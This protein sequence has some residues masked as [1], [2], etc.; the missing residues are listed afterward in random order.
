VTSTGKSPTLTDDEVALLQERQMAT[1]ATVMSDGSPQATP[2]W[3]D[4]D[5]EAIIFN[6]V[7]GHVKHRNLLRDPRVAVSVYDATNPFRTLI[8]RGVCELI[9]EG[10][11]A[12]IDQL[13]K[14]YLDLDEYPNRRPG[15]E[16]IIGRVTLTS[17]FDLFAAV[18]TQEWDNLE[19]GSTA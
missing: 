19:E 11:E 16:R 15:Q 8:A 17:K 3:V 9:E 18:S 12:H 14:K 7:K 6:T 2:V 10:A 4:T 13:A 5:G 1:I